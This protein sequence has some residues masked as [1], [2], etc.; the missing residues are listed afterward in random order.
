VQ[1]GTKRRQ[2]GPVVFRQ[3]GDLFFQK[4]DSFVL[5]YI[6]QAHERVV[7]FVSKQ[8]FFH[9]FEEENQKLSDNVNIRAFG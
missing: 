1:K 5:R 2:Y 3:L 6:W 4:G 8:W 7:Q 9:F